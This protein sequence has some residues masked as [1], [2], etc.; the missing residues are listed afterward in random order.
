MKIKLR[1]LAE[2]E[3]PEER[4]HKMQQK[5]ELIASYIK[6]PYHVEKVEYN[7][8]SY[9][10]PYH[11][12]ILSASDLENPELIQKILDDFTDAIR[13]TQDIL[14]TCPNIRRF[15]DFKISELKTN[16]NFLCPYVNLIVDI[17][18]VNEYFGWGTAGIGERGIK[19]YWHSPELTKEFMKES[20]ARSI[21]ATPPATTAH[22]MEHTL[23]SDKEIIDPLAKI[24]GLIFYLKHPEYVP[25]I[26]DFDWLCFEME[27]IFRAYLRG[28]RPAIAREQI[29][30]LYSAAP[31]KTDKCLKKV[32][33]EGDREKIKVIIKR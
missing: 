33:S 26:P 1:L 13:I 17:R 6:P 19:V 9:T 15:Y 29:N 21:E 12:G 30:A 20:I 3:T 31:E 22:E 2:A 8:I 11:E 5:G 10:S 32:F 28:D 7:S 16:K 23:G 25:E 24:V 14:K 18:P 4:L 27:Y